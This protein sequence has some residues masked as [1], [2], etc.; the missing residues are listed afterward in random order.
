MLQQPKPD[1]YVLATGE[2]HSVREFVERAFACVGIH[3]AWEG[4][5]LNEKGLDTSSGDVVVEVDAALFRPQEVQVLL[6]DA[7]KA[8]KTLGWTPKISF[9]A[10]V[11]EM[12]MADRLVEDVPIK[13]YGT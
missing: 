12:V 2:A 6:G 10:L 13:I 9:E 7:T 5:G 4:K 8:K 1:D 3:I 11:R